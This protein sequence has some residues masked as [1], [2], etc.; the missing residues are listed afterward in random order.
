MRGTMLL[1]RLAWRQE[2]LLIAVWT[3]A[4]V[5][6]CY[7]SAAATPSLYASAAERAQAAD[8]INGNPAV[9]ALY[10]PILDVHSTGELSMTKATVL[11]AVFVALLGMILVRRHTRTD[12][13]SG[14]TELVSAGVVG[15]H[16]PLSAAFAAATGVFV[17]LGVLVALADIAGGLPVGGSLVFGLSW[18]LLGLVGAALTLVAAQLVPS[19]RACAAIAGGMIGVLYLLRAVGDTSVVALSWLSPFGWAT[20]LRAWSG[21]R[22]WVL[23]LYAVLV[24]GLVV[25]AHALRG[26]RDLGAG[27]VTARPGPAAGSSYLGS[28][29]ALALRLHRGML[30]GWT[31]ALMGMGAL[32]GA[33]AP[34]VS[35][36][37]TGQAA[38]EMIRRLG[39]PGSL[40]R[41]LIAAEASIGALVVTVFA[42]SVISHASHDE[43]VGLAERTL[44][45]GSSRASLFAATLAVAAGGA[46]WLCLA[47]GIGVALGYR[48]DAV[49][50]ALSVLATAPA[51]LVVVGVGVLGWAWR[52]GWYVAGWVALGL[53]L[54]AD[55]IAQLLNLPTWVGGISP[56]SHLALVPSEGFR[57]VPALVL[58]LIAIALGAAA[59]VS[60]R[61]RDI[62]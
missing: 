31:I 22:W 16:A 26:R 62:G 50:V 3:L 33:I 20:Q 53:S 15:R 43:Q 34:G 54:V 36:L 4:L 29:L 17:L 48:R 27:L 45:S 10:G 35:G 37:L 9:V 52:P 46:L 8:G 47:T 24:A 28:S 41:T 32:M 11:Y 2:R 23:A 18:T 42:I 39:G 5:A 6:F 59:G 21:T 14:R 51:V 1:T 49:P 56:Y 60:Y 38:Q 61:R 19:A 30:I 7:A 44:S 12:E 57:A 25:L 13:E 58:V 40:E 55:Q